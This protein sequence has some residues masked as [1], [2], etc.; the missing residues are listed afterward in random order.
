MT[1]RQLLAAVVLAGL[2]LLPAKSAL[3]WDPATTHAGL[4]EGALEASKFHTTLAHQLGRALGSL[5]PLRLDA[6]ALDADIA[7][8][9]RIRLEALD[10][11]GGY[12]P[13]AEGVATASA[14]VRAGAVLAKTPPERGR[15]HFFEPK[16]R[17]GLDD[18]QIG[19]AHV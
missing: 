2:A 4:T 11:A 15:H 5:E 12:R 3:A 10:S 8:D 1:S 13:N 18:G 14:W 7:R 16:T 19:R 17:T 9:L 6:N